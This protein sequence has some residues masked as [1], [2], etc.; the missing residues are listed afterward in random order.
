MKDFTANKQAQFDST[1]PA[2]LTMVDKTMELGPHL[3][4]PMK[5]TKKNIYV[6][7]TYREATHKMYLTSEK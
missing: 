3:L 1:L 6:N 5:T 2:V 7:N 4:K